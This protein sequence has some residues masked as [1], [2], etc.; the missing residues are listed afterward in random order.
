MGGTIPEKL[1]YSPERDTVDLSDLQKINVPAR[2]SIFLE[3]T[4][5]AKHSKI[6]W[7]WQ[8]KNGDM[9]FYVVRCD[10]D[11]NEILVWPKFRLL[12]SFVPEYREV[13]F[14]RKL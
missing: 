4:V 1:H 6:C 3:L 9:D 14:L 11:K 12:T 5:T 2:S 13:I 10:G 8:T 7:W